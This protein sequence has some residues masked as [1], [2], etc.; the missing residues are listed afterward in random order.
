MLT[1][2]GGVTVSAIEDALLVAASVAAS[3][4]TSGTD[5]S[6]SSS[7]SSSSG[8]GTVGGN[9]TVIVTNNVAEAIIGDNAKIAADGDINITA[10]NDVDIFLVSMSVAVSTGSEQQSGVAMGGTIAVAVSNA[11]TNV[12]IGDNAE[13][14]STDGAITIVAD[15]NDFMLNILGRNSGCCNIRFRCRG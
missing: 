10:E 9:L 15:N 3:I 14:I 1:L 8:K 5:G 7:S 12:K 11:E 6:S 13:I 2:Q 4:A